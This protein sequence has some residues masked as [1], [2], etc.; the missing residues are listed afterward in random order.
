MKY[1]S[2]C[3][4]DRHAYRKPVCSPMKKVGVAHRKW[5]EANVGRFQRVARPGGGTSSMG[6]RNLR[7]IAVSAASSSRSTMRLGK[8]RNDP[9]MRTIISATRSTSR[10]TETVPD[11]CS[12][13][14]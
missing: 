11:A 1:R 2:Y 5:Q 13:R 12:R 8:A 6:T 10:S 14:S 4:D 9:V 3:I 7:A